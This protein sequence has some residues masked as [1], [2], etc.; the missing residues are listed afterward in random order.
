MGNSWSN[1]STTT[2]VIPTGATT[3]A[4]VVIDGTTGFISVYNAANQLVDTIGGPDGA[5]TVQTPGSQQLELVGGQ[6][7]FGTGD[8]TTQFPALISSTDVGQL[9]L[10]SG[11]NAGLPLNF[12]AQ[13]ELNQAVNPG[14]RPTAVLSEKAAAAPTDLLVGGAVIAATNAGVAH[15]WHTVGETGE[16]GYGAN[17]SATTSFAGL[18]AGEGLRFRRTAEDDTWLYGLAT[19][20]AGAG[21]T[22]F[23][24]TAGYYSTLHTT[25]GTVSRNRAGTVAPVGVAIATSGAV[26]LSAAPAAGDEYMFNFRI[27]V[28]NIS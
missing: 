22:V 17:W 19:T 26:L 13:L 18:G 15:T 11:S 8:I 4:R 14:G 16:P 27:P 6:I 20:A 7:E 9:T 3:G 10:T 25:Y 24:L 1:T 2:L 23:T 12:Q 5:I 28:E 21:T